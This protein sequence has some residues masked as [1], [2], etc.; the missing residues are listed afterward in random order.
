M[1]RWNFPGRE[2]QVCQ[3]VEFKKKTIEEGYEKDRSTALW[4]RFLRVFLFR[5]APFLPELLHRLTPRF[6]KDKCFVDKYYFQ[7]VDD[8]APHHTEWEYAVPYSKANEITTLIPGA[9]KHI[10]Y[11]VEV[12][13]RSSPRDKAKAHLAHFGDVVWF[14]LN[15]VTPKGL[16]EEELDEVAKPFEDMCVARGGVVHP[17]KLVVDIQKAGFSADTIKFLTAFQSENDPEKKMIN[18]ALSAMLNQPFP[19]SVYG[20]M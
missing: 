18:P 11:T 5:A 15:V 2:Y 8:P 7:Y 13:I 17:H 10:K 19:S 6:F 4:D 14:D 12:H 9:V 16:S 20:A 3:I 1:A